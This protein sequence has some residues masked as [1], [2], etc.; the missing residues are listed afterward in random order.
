MKP[1]M[2]A[3]AGLALALLVPRILT[4]DPDDAVPPDDLTLVT[5]LLD[6]C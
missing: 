4:D 3:G 6:G 2:A 1:G 5:A